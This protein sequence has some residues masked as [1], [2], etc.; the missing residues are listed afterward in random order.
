[1][2]LHH[3]LFEHI[4][5]FWEV[6]INDPMERFPKT[7]GLI[8]EMSKITPSGGEDEDKW[9]KKA[10]L[11]KDQINAGIKAGYE[12]IKKL[13]QTLLRAPMIFL[14]TLDPKVGPDILRAILA[15]VEEE[16]VDINS[17]TNYHDCDTGDK[18]DEAK[19][20]D[21]GVYKTDKIEEFSVLQM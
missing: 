14:A 10:N 13:Y 2:E 20:L 12:E 7:L 15:V 1:M 8:D 18:V 4:M 6:A 9:E 21:W 5:P 11:M 17:A 16:G 19:A 3:L